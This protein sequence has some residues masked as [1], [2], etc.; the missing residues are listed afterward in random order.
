MEKIKSTHSES[1]CSEPDSSDSD[2]EF[3]SKSFK[4][5][6]ALPQT[7]QTIFFCIKVNRKPTDLEKAL[8]KVKN[9]WVKQ[10]LEKFK[11]IGKSNDL[12]K[13]IYKY[14]KRHKKEFKTIEF[15]KDFQTKKT[16]LEAKKT[17]KKAKTKGKLVSGSYLT[18]DDIHQIQ[19]E[20]ESRNSIVTEAEPS[21]D[22]GASIYRESEINSDI[23][24]FQMQYGK[25]R[26]TYIMRQEDTHNYSIRTDLSGDVETINT[27]NPEADI[28]YRIIRHQLKRKDHPIRQII[29]YFT[30]LFVKSY[31]DYVNKSSADI[32][33][34]Y[35]RLDQTN[36]A[37]I[38]QLRD[39]HDVMQ[40]MMIKRT[41]ERKG[42]MQAADR[43]ALP[44]Y[45]LFNQVVEDV[46]TIIKQMVLTLIEFYSL[47]TKRA[48]LESIEEELVE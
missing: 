30:N 46:Q 41:S 17:K 22:M 33:E 31:K 47:I 34:L 43:T 6:S 3:S 15:L 23:K 40:K 10:L 25:V 9:R 4:K 14:L 38:S 37:V 20:N 19:A 29:A 27:L 35:E 45:F 1:D 24:E 44:M 12:I 32:E 36:K 2:S 48:N 5:E 13:Q 42:D 21:E 7:T 16:Q 26:S 11:A 39:S 8:G 18:E 28:T